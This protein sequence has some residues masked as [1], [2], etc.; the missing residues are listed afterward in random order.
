MLGAGTLVTGQILSKQGGTIASTYFWLL[1]NHW[2]MFLFENFH[3]K[4]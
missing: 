3:L 2:K 1:E 4:F